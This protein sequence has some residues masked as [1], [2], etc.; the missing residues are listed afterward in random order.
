MCMIDDAD[1]RCTVLHEK[2]Q[3]A[4]KEHVCAECHRTIGKGEVYLNEGLLFEGKINT[5]KTCAHCLVV[6]SWISKECGGWIYGEIKEDF[7]EHARNPFYEETLNYLCSGIQR[8]WRCQHE[9]LLPV[10]ER[11][12]T[13]HEREKETLR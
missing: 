6:R 13:T 3:R 8:R 9:Q 7:E 2:Q 10:S 5:H 1:E 11:P 4:R 12:M